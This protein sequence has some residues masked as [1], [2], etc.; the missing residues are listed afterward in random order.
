MF[1]CF[2]VSIACAIYNS[3]HGVSILNAIIEDF[4]LIFWWSLHQ[5]A[6]VQHD[7]YVARLQRLIFTLGIIIFGFLDKALM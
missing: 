5:R 2:L 7:Q 3:K 4:Y 1:P 6:S